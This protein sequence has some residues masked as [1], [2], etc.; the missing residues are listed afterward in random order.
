MLIFH[1][2]SGLE[3]C[4][5]AWFKILSSL[6]VGVFD[7]QMRVRWQ[8]AADALAG[9]ITLFWD[10][11]A[12]GN[13]RLPVTRFF[14]EILSYYKFHISEM[15]PIGMVRIRDFEFLCRSMHIESMVNRF[16]VFYQMHRSQGFYSFAQRAS[17]KK[18]L[19]NPPKSFHEWKPKFFFIKVG[20]I[21]MKMV[22][23]GKEDIMTETI[24]TPFSETWYRDLKELP[25][26][27]LLKK[28]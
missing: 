19:S 17:A 9:Y 4:L 3:K 10:Y 7:I 14:L 25:S 21:P 1:P 12:E 13:F 26:I 22:F 8:T 15:H 6:I 16:R 20:V 18:I 24:Q 23:R 2:C 11:F 5:I 27:E 28:A